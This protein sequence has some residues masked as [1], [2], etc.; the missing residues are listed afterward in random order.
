MSATLYSGMGFAL[1]PRTLLKGKRTQTF[2]RWRYLPVTFSYLAQLIYVLIYFQII[3]HSEDTGLANTNTGVILGDPNRRFMVKF[4]LAWEGLIVKATQ[5]NFPT[6]L[7][8][9]VERRID[10]YRLCYRK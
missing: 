2:T 8:L 5:K 3:L 6:Q 7:P 9:L 10:H 1:A 4:K